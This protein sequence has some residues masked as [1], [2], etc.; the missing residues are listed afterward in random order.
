MVPSSLQRVL[1]LE[2]LDGS[3]K[4]FVRLSFVGRSETISVFGFLWWFRSCFR[5]CG[6]CREN[7]WRYCCVML[8]GGMPLVN[9]CVV[10]SSL[11]SCFDP[12]GFANPVPRAYL[13]SLVDDGLITSLA[14]FPRVSFTGETVLT[15]KMAAR[16]EILLAQASVHSS[17]SR[18]EYEPLIAIDLCACVRSI[19]SNFSVSWG[20]SSFSL[21]SLHSL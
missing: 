9:S 15:S 1:L 5:C 17:V 14:T 18:N 7:W 4:M 11:L 20:A 2:G 10:R 21:A 19:T 6:P 13:D 3:E 8:C 12:Y 16:R